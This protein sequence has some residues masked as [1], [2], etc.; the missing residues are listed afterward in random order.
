M[1]TKINFLI[2]IL[3]FGLLGANASIGECHEIDVFT[4]DYSKEEPL[5]K[6]ILKDNEFIRDSAHSKD[7]Q[8][9]VYL[10][11]RNENGGSDYA[12]LIVVYLDN[13]G[14]VKDKIRKLS[15]NEMK[16]A[17]S[18]FCSILELGEINN[19]GSRLTAK[20]GYKSS[21][22]TPYKVTYEW[23]DLDIK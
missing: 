23:Q 1:P 3:L 18:L 21:E 9:A 15:L 6:D 14:G 2:G 12:C 4:H 16:R 8:T 19:G 22:E 13:R 5:I 7:K 11:S 17:N 10:I 20:I